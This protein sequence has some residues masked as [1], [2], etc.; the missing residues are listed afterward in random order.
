MADEKKEKPGLAA[1]KVATVAKLLEKA[2]ELQE[3]Q[4]AILEEIDA[5]LGGRAG[6][7]AK[8]KAIEKGFDERWCNRYAKGQSGVYVWNYVRDRPHMKALLRKMDVDELLTRA[9]R[10]LRSEDGFHVKNRHSF[11]LFVSSI[12]H[13]AESAPGNGEL[14]LEGGVADCQHEPA[15]RSEQEHTRRKMAEMRQ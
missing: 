9:D 14:D 10:Y 12:N 7:A 1:A 2:K 11:G 3:H 5:I 8:L 6:T 15:C 13:W 4:A